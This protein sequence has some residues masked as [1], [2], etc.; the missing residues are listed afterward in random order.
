MNKA[1]VYL[2]SLIVLCCVF[3]SSLTNLGGMLGVD[4]QYAIWM[5]SVTSTFCDVDG[6]DYVLDV[7]WREH[8]NQLC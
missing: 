6:M 7:R 1:S 2:H 8:D 4:R 3:N 5:L